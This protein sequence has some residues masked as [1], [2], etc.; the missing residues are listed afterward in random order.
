MSDEYILNGRVARNRIALDIKYRKLK[1]AGIERLVTDPKISSAFIGS[2]FKAKK[3]RKYWNKSYLDELALAAIA[4]SFNRDYLLYLDE[5]AEFVANSAASF[6]KKISAG[7]IIAFIII[8]GI[9]IYKCSHSGKVI[10]QVKEDEYV[11]DEYVEDEYIENEYVEDKYAEDEYIENEYVEDKYVEDEVV[12]DKY[13]EDEV[14][15][16]TTESGL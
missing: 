14:V 1:R 4:E 2:S 11:E 7:F 6:K 8:M 9:I 15:E 10:E 5:V 16:S 3:A 13:V 12:E